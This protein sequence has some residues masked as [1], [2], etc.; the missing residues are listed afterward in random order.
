MSSFD[1][2]ALSLVIVM[3]LDFPVVFATQR[4]S[5]ND[6]DLRFS[7]RRRR[8][9]R[10]LE[11]AGKVVATRHL[12]LTLIHLDEHIKL[13]VRVSKE[14]LRILARGSRVVL[15]KDGHLPTSS[16]DTNGE[17]GDVKREILGLLRYVAADDGG[18]DSSTKGNG[19]V[20]VDRLVRLLGIE[21]TDKF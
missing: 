12:A 9:A 5:E 10:E 3:R 18:L 13:F 16:L 7:T 17:R 11:L 2:R 21:V 4:R 8:D 15:D 14:D 6:F 19:L 20:G 1:K